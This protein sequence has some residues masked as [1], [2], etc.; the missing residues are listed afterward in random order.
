V[1]RAR[2]AVSR[3]V[4]QWRGNSAPA[5]AIPI[6]YV[7]LLMITHVVAFYLLVRPQRQAARALRWLNGR[8]TRPEWDPA[9]TYQGR[10]RV[11]VSVGSR[12]CEN[13][14]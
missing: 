1:T 11:D 8:M 6:I 12:L 10:H 13:P 9:R 4:V 2:E 5:Y 7:P 14:I 3:H